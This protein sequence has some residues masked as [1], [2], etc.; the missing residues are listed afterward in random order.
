VVSG[1]QAKLGDVQAQI[2]TIDGT[3]ALGGCVA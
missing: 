2:K 3:I 1:L